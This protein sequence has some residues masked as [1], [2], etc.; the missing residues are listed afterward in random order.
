[1]NEILALPYS[2]AV[3]LNYHALVASILSECLPE[4]AFEKLQSD[5]PE[6]VQNQL[7]EEDWDDMAR[8]RLQGVYYKELSE[9]YCLDK[10]TIYRKLKRLGL[11]RFE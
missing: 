10:A 5:E 1:M 6:K 9:I 8:L 3:K 7:T 4:M 11:K 2:Q